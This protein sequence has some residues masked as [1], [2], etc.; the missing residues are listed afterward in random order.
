VIQHLGLVRRMML[1]VAGCAVA[2]TL[3]ACGHD[4]NES[5]NNTSNRGNVGSGGKN[6]V[7][8]PRELVGQWSGVAD[9]VSDIYTFGTDGT[10]TYTAT[11]IASI[12]CSGNFTVSGSTLYLKPTTRCTNRTYQWEISDGTLY[13]T[14]EDGY[15]ATYH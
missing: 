15:R 9:G 2:F 6:T 8:V 5:S 12:S 13:L 1:V 3:A 10:Y 4:D 11:A 14:N 7:T